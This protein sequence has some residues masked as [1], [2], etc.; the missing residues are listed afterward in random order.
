MKAIVAALM[1]GVALSPP[2]SAWAEDVP[3]AWAYAMNPDF[4]PEP[5]DG[6]LRHV[7]DS[8]AA[9]TLTQARDLFSALDWHPNDHRRFPR[10]SP[11]FASPRSGRVAFA[12]ARTDRADRKMP[13]SPACRSSISYS[14]W[15]IATTARGLPR[16]RSVVRR[17]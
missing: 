3:P 6:K 9:Y 5:D 14:R 11:T 8:T 13:A 2:G 7:P 15:P 10:S 4:K 1:L 16:C 17:D 12:I